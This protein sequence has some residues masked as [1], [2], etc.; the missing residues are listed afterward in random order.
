MAGMATPVT[1]AAVQVGAD[2]DDLRL[3]VR[4]IHQ[5][6]EV[7]QHRPLGQLDGIVVNTITSSQKGLSPPREWRKTR[8]N[9]DR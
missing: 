9:E 5:A 1:V 6:D 7:G 2:K 8:P 4:P 3:A